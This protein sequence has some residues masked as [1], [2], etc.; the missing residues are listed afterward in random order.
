MRSLL[1]VLNVIGTLLAWFAL[2]FMLPILTGLL[3]GERY[4]LRGFIVGGLISAVVGLTLKVLT[5]RYRHDLKPRDAFLLV[6]AGWLI[7][8][9]VATTPLLLDVRGL[10]YTRA[11]FE[12]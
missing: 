1:A 6:S 12:A 9:A 5:R 2:F 7:I 4:A 11:Y 10:S 3:Y 8:A